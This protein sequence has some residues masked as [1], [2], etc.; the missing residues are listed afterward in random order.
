MHLAQLLDRV[1]IFLRPR[2]MQLRNQEMDEAFPEF[3]DLDRFV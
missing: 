2:L 3:Y 1:A